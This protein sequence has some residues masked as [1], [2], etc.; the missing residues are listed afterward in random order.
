MIDLGIIARF[1]S[2]HTNSEMGIMTKNEPKSHKH[3]VPN[4]WP[5]PEKRNV[6]KASDWMEEGSPP[7]R[8]LG[9]N[10]CPTLTIMVAPGGRQHHNLVI[11]TPSNHS[12]ARPK[13]SF[14]NST[15]H[16]LHAYRPK[17]WFW[18]WLPVQPESNTKNWGLVLFKKFHIQCWLLEQAGKGERD[19]WMNEYIYV[20]E[21]LF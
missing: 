20:Q 4:N 15:N 6:L 16:H 13:H 17:S 18:N 1:I 2:D 19:K 21:Y 9:V 11:K 7:Y 3:I 12:F 5:S 10:G 14:E 8:G